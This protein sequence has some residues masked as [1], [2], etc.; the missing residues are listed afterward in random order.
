MAVFVVRS[1]CY[2]LCDWFCCPCSDSYHKELEW[3]IG[4]VGVLQ[5]LVTTF[6]RSAIQFSDYFCQVSY[7]SRDGHFSDV[8][9]HCQVT[10]LY[11]VL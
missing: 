2:T 5:C 4:T 7:I 1:V 8:Y 11:A 6:V 3:V 9:L 10:A